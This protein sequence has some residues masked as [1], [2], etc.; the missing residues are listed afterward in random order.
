MTPI[1]VTFDLNRTRLECKD[2]KGQLLQ[3]VPFYLNR[4]RLEC[5]E[6]NHSGVKSEGGI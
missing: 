5:K 4:T 1:S 2:G 6:D 3:C